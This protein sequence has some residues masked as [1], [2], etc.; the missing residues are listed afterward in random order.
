[1]YKKINRYSRLFKRYF[2]VNDVHLK[3]RMMFIAAIGA[4][5][6]NILHY[7]LLL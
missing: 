2:Y 7:I 6:T 1:M 4:N 5:L 3:I